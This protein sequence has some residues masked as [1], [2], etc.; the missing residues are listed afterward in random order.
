MFWKD[1]EEDRYE[2]DQL[3]VADP[4]NQ[5]SCGPIYICSAS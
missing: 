4:L 5:V 2:D 1:E 3:T